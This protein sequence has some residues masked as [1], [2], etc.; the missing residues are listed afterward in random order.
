M[1][2]IT[3]ITADIIDSRN[4]PNFE[5]SLSAKLAKLDH[6]AIISTFS[7]SRGD[8]IQGIT[9]GWL[10]A[11]EIIRYLRY[12]CR[13]LKLRI[14]IGFGAIEDD[15]IEKSSW[16]MNGPPFYLA[17]TA[18]E[19]VQKLRDTLTLIKTGESEFDK[20]VNCIWLLIDTIQD[21]W[22]DEQWEAVH[23]YDSNGTY[24]EASKQLGISMQNVQ[25]R[26]K[27]ARWNQINQAE[28]I[29][30]EIQSYLG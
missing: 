18:L 12:H 3:V 8:E 22:T 17:R 13:P 14:G 5:K 30:K 25:K 19:E 6:P 24:E 26:C 7:I 29:L 10:T 23:I 27:A 4:H 21:R 9:E 11:P 2:K 20:F 15:E 16:L 1:R 28:K